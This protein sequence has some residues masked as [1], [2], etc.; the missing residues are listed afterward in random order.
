MTSNQ[1]ISPQRLGAQSGDSST[2]GK[3]QAAIRDPGF[4][5]QIPAVYRGIAPP[6][7][8]E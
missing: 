4:A 5:R 3:P 8:L 7:A 2:V 1:R 6:Q